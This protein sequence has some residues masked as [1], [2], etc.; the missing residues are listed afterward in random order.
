M[1]NLSL[2]KT[3]RISSNLTEIVNVRETEKES[4]KRKEKERGRENE[5]GTESAATI[6]ITR[7]V[8]VEVM[9]ERGEAVG[10]TGARATGGHPRHL[11]PK[12]EVVDMGITIEITISGRMITRK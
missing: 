8:G 11:P 5:S 6:T 3:I 1:I 4:V 10:T 2:R 12:S 9:T 7:G